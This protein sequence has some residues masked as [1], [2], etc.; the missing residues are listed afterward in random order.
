MGGA[1]TE[2]MCCEIFSQKTTVAKGFLTTVMNSRNCSLLESYQSF[3]IMAIKVL[4]IIIYLLCKQIGFAAGIFNSVDVSSLI[5]YR[6]PVEIVSRESL[7][8]STYS[9]GLTNNSRSEISR[10]QTS[11]I[12]KNISSLIVDGITVEFFTMT[13]STSSTGLMNE[14]SLVI[15]KMF[16]SDFLG[17]IQSLI[18][19]AHVDFIA[20]DFPSMSGTTNS[21]GQ[22]RLNRY[23]TSTWTSTQHFPA[24]G[25]LSYLAECFW[26]LFHKITMARTLSSAW[27]VRQ[28]LRHCFD[29]KSHRR[30]M[31]TYQFYF[32]FQIWH[33]EMTVQWCSREAID[34]KF[35]PAYSSDNAGDGPELTEEELLASMHYRRK[36]YAHMVKQK[37]GALMPYNFLYVDVTPVLPQPLIIE[38]KNYITRFYSKTENSISKSSASDGIPK[39]LDTERPVTNNEGGQC[40]NDAKKLD[41]T[42]K[43]KFIANYDALDSVQATAMLKDLMRKNKVQNVASFNVPI[44]MLSERLQQLT[45]NDR[46]SVI[47][48]LDGKLPGSISTLKRCKSRHFVSPTEDIVEKNELAASD[49]STLSQILQLRKRSKTTSKANSNSS[50]TNSSSGECTQCGCQHFSENMGCCQVCRSYGIGGFE[51]CPCRQCGVAQGRDESSSERRNIESLLLKEKSRFRTATSNQTSKAA[52]QREK[53]NALLD[54]KTLRYETFFV[55]WAGNTVTCCRNGFFKYYEMERA[56]FFRR[57]QDLKNNAE[58]SKSLNSSFPIEKDAEAFCRRLDE[59]FDI[60]LNDTERWTTR[61][62]EIKS[63]HQTNGAKTNLVKIALHE[64][65]SWLEDYFKMNAEDHP[66]RDGVRYIRHAAMTKMQ[67][68]KLYKK[69]LIHKVD[70]EGETLQGRPLNMKTLSYFRFCQ[71]WRESFPNVKVQKFIAVQTKCHTCAYLD[72]LAQ[73][74]TKSNP[75]VMGELRDLRVAHATFYRSQR[76]Y[77]HD[78]KEKAAQN[79]LGCFSCIGDGMAQAHNI[80]P[81]YAKSGP[82]VAAMTFDTHFQGFITHHHS[83]TIFRSFGNVGKGTNVA[84]HAWLV[85]LEEW[86]KNHDNT[87]PDHIAYQVDGGPENAS[88]TPIGMA[89][90]LVHWGLT[91]TVTITRLPPG[92]THAD[93]D[94]MFGVIW[95]HNWRINL[96]SPQQQRDATIEAFKANSKKVDVVDVFAVPDYRKYFK[97][98][99]FISRAFHRMGINNLGMLHWKITSHPVSPFFPLGVKTT[100]FA[101]PTD[102]A[103]EIV[104]TAAFRFGSDKR[105][106]YVTGL[107]PMRTIS[108]ERPTSE[109]NDGGPPGMIAL[110]CLPEG[111]PEVA[112]FKK[113]C[114]RDSKGILTAFDVVEHLR[115]MVKAILDAHGSQSDTYKDWV[116]FLR[117]FPAG[118]AKSYVESEGNN[119]AVPFVTFFDRSDAAYR[120]R[121][122]SLYSSN[123]NTSDISDIPIAHAQ[124]TVEWGPFGKG[125]LHHRVKVQQ[126]ARIIQNHEAHGL[127]SPH[128]HS[129]DDDECIL[130]SMAYEAML[131]TTLQKYCRQRGLPAI[132]QKIELVKRL[133]DFDSLVEKVKTGAVNLTSSVPYNQ[134]SSK[135]LQ[136][137]LQTCG[138]SKS[139]NKEVLLKRLLDA[140]AKAGINIESDRNTENTKDEFI[141]ARVKSGFE[142]LKPSVPY[143]KMTIKQLQDILQTCGLSKTGKK[144]VLLKRIMDAFAKAGIDVSNDIDQAVDSVLVERKNDNNKKDNLEGVNKK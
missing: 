134:M 99:C 24:S 138:L 89:E 122:E 66:N 92:H 37:R 2:K 67:L 14:S 53:I 140:F 79:P 128:L 71:L 100:F 109:D 137:V 6:T 125:W 3:A 28:Y 135:Q 130:D 91:K 45:M 142:K 94:G 51:K 59:T 70:S 62:P 20:R 74:C 27:L 105:S 40:D 32:R 121:K 55:G 143:N 23:K 78:I 25:C 54:K 56:T 82:Q 39:Q 108:I 111:V 18:V 42:A 60:K 113:I 123:N 31:G 15:S 124:A 106:K 50:D 21:A 95:S 93:I 102:E 127:V 65:Q 30:V 81:S 43:L 29:P 126:E 47:V 52:Y 131:N 136:D 46:P 48:P 120:R 7:T 87:L 49:D 107:E 133:H 44:T 38:M 139:G 10:I 97:G 64:C 76:K 12:T 112:E 4:V 118:D 34:N 132:G 80:L 36:F 17:D 73:E 13:E 90:L 83:F 116:A 8:M 72:Q 101:Y 69:E 119:Y 84:L 11:D 114:V 16:T 141:D 22:K 86:Y 5:S 104:K 98:C 77:Y 103:I 85:H 9:A 33:T 88:S 57:L 115:K 144:E 96:L 26:I 61:I 68:W 110:S 63:Y 75:N 35:G 19:D 117:L 1:K 41:I 129:T 58:K